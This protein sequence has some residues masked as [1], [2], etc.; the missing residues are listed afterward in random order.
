MRPQWQFYITLLF[1]RAGIMLFTKVICLLVILFYHCYSP[2]CLAIISQHPFPVL[3]D[4]PI[5]ISPKLPSFNYFD[6]IK[7]FLCFMVHI[8]LS[9]WLL[10]LPI[11]YVRFVNCSANSTCTSRPGR[12]SS[13]SLIPSLYLIYVVLIV[14]NIVV[15]GIN[16]K[17]QRL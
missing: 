2:S 11:A 3:H 15:L 6:G 16:F 9:I 14:E 17:Y 4:H 1:Q 12:S 13:V 10:Y 5:K 8:N 7:I